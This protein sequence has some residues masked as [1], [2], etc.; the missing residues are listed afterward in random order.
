MLIAPSILSADFG[1]INEEIVAAHKAGADW[2][3]LDVMDGQFVPNLTFGPPV[4]E[5]FPKIPGLVMDAHLMVLNPDQ[6]VPGFA[7]AGIHTL[8]VHQEACPHLHRTIQNIHA[9][10]MRAGVSLNPA[11]PVEAIDYVLEDV[12]LVLV[13]SVNPGFGGQKYIPSATRKIA[14]LQQRKQ[15]RGLKFTI[16][17]DGGIT[18]Q[19]IGEA[20]AAGAQCFV[21]GTAVFGQKDY[22]QAIAALRA[23]AEQAA[24]M[25]KAA[26]R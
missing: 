17:V 9:N 15:Q 25:A 1:R 24:P 12:D 20:A 11:T 14:A 22:A 19:T 2:M 7:K 4:A 23:A 6:L 8:T 21:A 26:A 16:Q 5:K 10:G 13:M 3:H 18:P